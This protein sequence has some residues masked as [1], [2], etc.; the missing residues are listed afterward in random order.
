LAW[1]NREK[2]IYQV[3]GG[4]YHYSFLKNLELDDPYKILIA[5]KTPPMQK[6]YHN[7]NATSM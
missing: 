4:K 6:F 3:A 2:G 5:L 1:Y 7:I